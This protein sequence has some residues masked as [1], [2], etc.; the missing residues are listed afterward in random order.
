MLSIICAS[1][2]LIQALHGAPRL[3]PPARPL[4]AI[5]RM[6][7]EAMQE[8]LAAHRHY[9][10]LRSKGIAHDS[11]LRHALALAPAPSR[12]ACE[13]LAPLWFAGKA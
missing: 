7:C 1:P 11:A 6:A 2:P 5:L 13:A 8:G 3:S 4:F 10:E 9:E 12:A